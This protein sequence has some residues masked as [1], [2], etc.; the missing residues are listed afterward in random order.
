MKPNRDAS[1]LAA[2]LGAAANKP[3]PLPGSQQTIER[4]PV[5]REQNNAKEKKNN[6]TVGISLRPTKELL[7]RYTIAAAERTMTEGRVVSAQEVMLEV[8]NKGP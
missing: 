2:R 4:Q 3:V 5:R 1:E 6:T 7:A 8:L